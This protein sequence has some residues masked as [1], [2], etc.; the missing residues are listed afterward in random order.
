MNA[1][2]TTR[3]AMMLVLLALGSTPAAPAQVRVTLHPDSR[4][5]ISGT[6]S[7]SSFTCTASHVEGSSLFQ[8]GAARVNA[9]VTVPV[10]AF[11]CRNGRMSRDLYDALQGD[12]HP[13]IRF[14][15][16]TVELATEMGNTETYPL[17]ASGRL[18]IAGSTQPVVLHVEGKKRPDGTYRATGDLTL[19]MTTFGITPPTALMGL[20]KVH[21]RITVR[22]DLVAAVRAPGSTP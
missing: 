20:I 9:T 10:D 17:L 8:P 2:A 18:T 12:D 11:D 19:Q 3:L 15:L 16:D 4:I 1:P 21:D 6:S 7:V 22:F 13:H 14:T 5:A